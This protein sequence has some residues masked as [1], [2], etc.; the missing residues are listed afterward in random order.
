MEAI[1][2]RIAGVRARIRS[3]ALSCGRDPESVRLVAVSKTRTPEEIRVAYAA[4]IRDFGENYVQEL[5]SKAS[6]LADLTD[7][8]FH[9][10]GHLQ[11][12]K[13]RYAARLASMVH[14]VHGV[15]LAQE[16]GKRT[17]DSL[18]PEARRV[19]LSV[20][21]GQFGDGAGRLP[22]LVEVNV[23][24]EFEKSGCRAQELET[25]LAAVEAEPSLWLR[26]L[27]TVPPI[28]ETAEGARPFF[29]E[30]SRLRDSHGGPERLPELSM[31][32]T[33][34]MEVAIRAGA[35]QVRVGTAIFG[36]RVYRGI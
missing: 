24:G 28:T 29:E 18:V 1:A 8:R 4:G 30:L 25:V 17:R 20:G 27:M 6:I 12:N 33:H 13:A 7:L 23:G 11:R 36:D 15:E 5:D 3:A 19:P 31:G 21:A 35:T 22:V 32:M 16:L 2:D 9:M 14:S 26:G 10:I 34:D